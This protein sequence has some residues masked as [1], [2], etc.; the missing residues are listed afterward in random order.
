VFR[1]Y[2][3]KNP[4]TDAE[5]I[6]GFTLGLEFGH[7][8]GGQVAEFASKGLEGS[9][10]GFKPDLCAHPGR[11]AG[12][13]ENDARSGERT[14]AG[15]L[16]YITLQ[17]RRFVA[18]GSAWSHVQSAPAFSIR[19]HSDAASRSCGTIISKLGSR[20]ISLS[21]PGSYRPAPGVTARRR[22]VACRNKFHDEGV[23]NVHAI[24]LKGRSRFSRTWWPLQG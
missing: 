13:L 15:S 6:A 2:G 16:C 23:R 1:S 17:T 11:T 3:R 9:A 18:R 22:N 19:P 4:T 14:Q 21:R 7:F 24:R 10:Q 5:H 12:N 8:V 20:A